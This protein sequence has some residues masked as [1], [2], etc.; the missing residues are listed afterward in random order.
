[1]FLCENCGPTIS[2]FEMFYLNKNP[3][4]LHTNYKRM[5][6]RK[7]QDYT[8]DSHEMYPHFQLSMPI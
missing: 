5:H 3:V 8:H 1:M 4:F 6:L 2:Q 7:Y